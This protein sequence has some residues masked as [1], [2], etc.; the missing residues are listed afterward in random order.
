ME[1]AHGGK[2][3][4]RRRQRSKGCGWWWRSSWWRRIWLDSTCRSEWS[5][6]LGLSVCL[7]SNFARHPFYPISDEDCFWWHIVYTHT[8]IMSA[9]FST[10]IACVFISCSRH[11]FSMCVCVFATRD[12]RKTKTHHHISCHLHTIREKEH[13]YCVRVK[14]TC[15]SCK[16]II[17]NVK[18]LALFGRWTDMF[19]DDTAFERWSSGG[20]DPESLCVIQGVDDFNY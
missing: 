10:T 14:R 11:F 9:L 1:S 2:H 6:C 5:I 16:F 3:R 17:E 4:H 13:F 19:G 12:G 18:T 15:R 8:N 20:R 7:T